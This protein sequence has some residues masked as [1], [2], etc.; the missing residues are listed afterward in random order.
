MTRTL[1]VRTCPSPKAGALHVLDPLAFVAQR[2]FWFD[3]PCGAVRGGHAHRTCQ[4]LV[5]PVLGTVVARARRYVRGRLRARTWRLTPSAALVV[6]PLVWLDLEFVTDGI[7]VVLASEGYN[8]AE[9]INT[10]A[11][12]RRLS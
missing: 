10:L 5:I 3:A 4:Q 8:A 12:L 7:C 9:Y 11:E 6:P 1:P 2:L